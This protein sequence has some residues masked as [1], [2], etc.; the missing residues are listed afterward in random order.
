M[1]DDD[2]VLFLTDI[3]EGPLE[4]GV[5]SLFEDYF[6]GDIDEEDLSEE[7]EEVLIESFFYGIM[8]VLSIVMTGKDPYGNSVS[9][10]HVQLWNESIRS[11]KER[12]AKFQI[13]ETRGQEAEGS[14]TLADRIAEAYKLRKAKTQIPANCDSKSD[15][16]Q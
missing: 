1:E 11:L 4:D 2:Q 14:E 16:D 8:W 3:D 13:P 9:A 7:L 15:Q 10:S 6:K 12:Y 5:D